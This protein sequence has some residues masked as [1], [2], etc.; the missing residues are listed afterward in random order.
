MIIQKHVRYKTEYGFTLNRQIIVDDIRVR[1]IGKTNYLRDIIRLDERKDK[2]LKAVGS[3]RVYFDGEYHSTN[4]YK[5]EEI[6]LND[7]IQGPAI[8]IDKIRYLIHNNF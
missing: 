1:G 5:I 2:G 8:I 6:L 3:S 7:R 4:L